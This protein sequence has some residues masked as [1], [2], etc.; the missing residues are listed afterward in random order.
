MPVDGNPA[1]A[2]E[3]CMPASDQP[4]ET[5]AGRSGL[6]APPEPQPASSASTN[7]RL[8]VPPLRFTFNSV[9]T[10][11]CRTLKS[12]LR[13]MPKSYSKTNGQI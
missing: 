9:A 1:G 12:D 11:V 13:R 4:G 8:E 5:D 2:A 10:G 6:D 3:D 7:S